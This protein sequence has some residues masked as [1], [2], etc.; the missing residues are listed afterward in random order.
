[1]YALPVRDASDPAPEAR[2]LRQNK[3][4][5]SAVF[6]HDGK[7]I[8][9]GVFRQRMCDRP[10]VFLDHIALTVIHRGKPFS[11]FQCHLRVVF[12]VRDIGTASVITGGIVVV[13][14]VEQS[15]PCRRSRIQTELAADEVQKLAGSTNINL[16]GSSVR[17]DTSRIV[18][19]A[20]NAC[21]A[22]AGEGLPEVFQRKDAQG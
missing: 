4:Q 10:H 2:R 7:N 17:Q 11:S 21:D 12:A 8:A 3:F 15:C 16:L 1:M 22:Q 6:I 13:E 9:L 18:E 5:Y 14:V 19:A 20:V